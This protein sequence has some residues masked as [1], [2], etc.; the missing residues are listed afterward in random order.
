MR[1]AS[2]LEKNALGLAESTIMCVAG[3]APVFS[4]AATS[5]TFIAAVVFCVRLACMVQA[6]QKCLQPDLTWWSGH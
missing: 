5:A 1:A 4:I 3:T 2:G 6:A